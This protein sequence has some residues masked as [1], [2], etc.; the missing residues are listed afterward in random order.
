MKRIV[1]IVDTLAISGGISRMVTQKASWLA[2]R[3]YDV[4]VLTTEGDGTDSYFPLHPEVKVVPLNINFLKVYDNGRGIR[5][6]IKSGFDRFRKERLFRLRCSEFLNKERYDIV[7]TT[8]NNSALT[9]M[10]DGSRKVYE[11]H[12]SRQAVLE[13]QKRLPFVSRILYRL[14][15]ARQNSR[16]G[17]YDV[18]VLLTERDRKL[19]GNPANA[20]VIPN[21]ITV[22][23][24]E[25]SPNYETKRVISVG[26]LSEAKN[27]Y[28]LFQAWALVK[29]KHPD[30]R[31]D[32]YGYGYGREEAHMEVMRKYGVD[33]VVTLHP[34]VKDIQ[35][36]YLASSFYVMSSIYEGF[37]L[38]LTEA[39]ACGLPCVSYDC[40]CGPSEIIRNGE[41]GLVVPEVND[42]TRLADAICWMV[43][44]PERRREM[45]GSARRNVHRLDIDEVMSQWVRLIEER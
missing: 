22:D 7:F 17:R 4:T 3:G 2:D 21:F 39:M 30:W 28:N 37:P 43:E 9:S 33:D 44:H 14:Y 16:L 29:K 34:P 31:L 6:M 19:R 12:F 38:V 20:R 13:F 15:D 25:S 35:R 27:Y 41:D 42:A 11:T 24:P 8:V 36:A 1:Y 45:G 23:T 5:G 10:K 32:I 26:R 18:L 40:N